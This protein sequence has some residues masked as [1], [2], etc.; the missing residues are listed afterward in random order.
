MDEKQKDFN[1]RLEDQG[2]SQEEIQITIE[3]IELSD[4]YTT[5]PK[6][7]EFK[8]AAQRLINNN[9]DVMQAGD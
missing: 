7:S 6:S 4:E 8:N 5:N 1:R 9:S 3:L 2:F